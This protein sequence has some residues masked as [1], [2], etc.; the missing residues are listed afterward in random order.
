VSR[1]SDRRQVAV[2]IAPQAK[3]VVDHARL[4]QRGQRGLLVAQ[5]AMRVADRIEAHRGTPPV[6]EADRLLVALRALLQRGLA[7]LLLQ[8][9]TRGT[10]GLLA[11][12][13]GLLLR[14]R[15]ARERARVI[16]DH[17][18][19]RGFVGAA[20]SEQRALV[21]RLDLVRVRLRAL[22]D[23][24]QRAFQIAVDRGQHQRRVLLP[25][26]DQRRPV[27]LVRELDELLAHFLGIGGQGNGGGG[28]QKQRQQHGR[29]VSS[30]G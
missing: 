30:G 26:L 20:R 9:L 1:R 23:L 25:Q 13:E 24:R 3:I 12:A 10:R 15:P 8:R 2:L 4:A 16:E 19:A 21:Q 27:L 17:R 5:H 14:S 7:V 18:M 11:L 6:A 29:G 22:L 28:N